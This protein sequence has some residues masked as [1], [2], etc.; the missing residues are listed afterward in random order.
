M[1]T[2]LKSFI[3]IYKPH[4]FFDSVDVTV[5]VEFI[6]VDTQEQLDKVIDDGD[7]YDYKVINITSW[8]ANEGEWLDHTE[9]MLYPVK[10][11]K[12]DT[13]ISDKLYDEQTRKNG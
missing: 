8:D 6:G 3:G 1:K 12:I 2:L 7:C 10:A 9:D 13:L 4:N 5:D 11:A